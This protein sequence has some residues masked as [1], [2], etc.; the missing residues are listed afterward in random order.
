VHAGAPPPLPLEQ[1]ELVPTREHDEQPEQPEL[2]PPELFLQFTALPTTIKMASR[3]I[4]RMRMGPT[5][6]NIMPPIVRTVL[7]GVN[8][9]IDVR[10][11]RK[12]RALTVL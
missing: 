5:P 4:G 3:L 7:E 2:E 6:Q 1:P 8:E 12:N 11:V 10:W 9:R